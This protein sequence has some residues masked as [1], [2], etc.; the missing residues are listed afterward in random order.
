MT[1]WLGRL[2]FAP[3]G[4]HVMLSRVPQPPPAALRLT[5]RFDRHPDIM[6]TAPLSPSG[7]GGGD[8]R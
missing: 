7:G 8:G 6:V 1:D 5:L 3:G 2:W 4:L